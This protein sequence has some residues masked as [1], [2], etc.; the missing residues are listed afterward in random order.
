MAQ[1]ND[2]VE[3]IPNEVNMLEVSDD[4][5]ANGNDERSIMPPP[6]V[7]PPPAAN[8]TNKKSNVNKKTDEKPIRST[9]SKQ[10]AQ[11]TTIKACQ[12]YLFK[13]KPE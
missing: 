4:E 8:R 12:I 11:S 1:G 10:V 7:V 2:S 6:A 9:R 13:H 3:I 5:E